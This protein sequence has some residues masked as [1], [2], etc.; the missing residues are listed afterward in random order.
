[1]R[2]LRSATVIGGALALTLSV[3]L[4]G[5]GQAIASGHPAARPAVAGSALPAGHAWTV[6]LVTGDIV[7]VRTVAGRPPMVAIQPGPGRKH[8]IFSSFVSSAGLIEVVPQDAMPTVNPA[9]FDVTVLIRGPLRPSRPARPAATTDPLTLKATPL[10][11]TASGDMNAGAFVVNLS[12][13]SL[14]EKFVNVSATGTTIHVPAGHYWVAGEVDDMTNPAQE[15]SAYTG[16]PEVAVEHPTTLTLNGAAAVPVTASAAEHPTQMTQ[17]SIH[18]ERTFD[19]Q[20]FATDIYNFSTPPKK[21]VLF[22]QPSGTA[23][24]GTFRPFIAFRLNSPPGAAH[25]Y[26]YDLYHLAGDRIPASMTYTVTPAAQRAMA[27]V[28]ARFYAV[29]G[30]TSTVMDTRYGLTATGFLA[31]QN[32]SNVAGGTTRTDFLSTEAGITWDQEASPPLS[33]PSSAGLWVTELPR[34][35]HYTPGSTQTADWAR[36]PFRPGPYSATIP[37]VSDCAPPPTTRNRTVLSV[38]LV[39]L[40][41]LPDGFDCLGGVLPLPE[42]QKATSRSLRLYRNGQLLASDHQSY[43]NFSVPVAAGS[44][45][46]SYTDDTAAALPVSTKTM[47]AWT[48][49]SAAPAGSAAVR[50]PLLVVSYALPLGLDNHP[51]GSK[52]EFSV[53]RIAGIPRAKVTSFELWAKAGT[54]GWQRLGVHALGGGRFSATLPHA[55]AGQAV[56]LRVKAADSGGSG[57]DQTILTAYH[58]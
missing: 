46:I 22:A 49:T 4:P 35:V 7:H 29:D 10:P 50:I 45:K 21:P 14:F 3:G 36:E 20:V 42:W 55:A 9:R 28:N 47:T 37:S 5:S 51:D 32:I 1:M 38:S 26:V 2:R 12:N 16:Q 24:T 17:G 27:R 19:G 48:F 39:D 18:V 52:A 13:P 43:G 25:A 11:G 23:Q 33:L 40:Q 53:A 8:V 34:F 54:G 41:N 44:Y 31:L 57:I 58:G 56:S 30:N 6:R 15:R